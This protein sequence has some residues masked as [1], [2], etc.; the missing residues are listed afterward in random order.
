MTTIILLSCG[1]KKENQ[2]SISTPEVSQPAAEQ[3]QEDVET[4]PEKEITKLPDLTIIAGS[5][6][7]QG[8]VAPKTVCKFTFHVRNVGNGDYDHT[9]MV[10]GPGI[11]QGFSSLKAGETKTV[12]VEY[13]P[14][15]KNA[16]YTL[17]FKVDPDNVIKESNESNNESQTFTIKTT[18]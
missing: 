2:N 17:K 6:S 13:T 16:T 9:I 10:G 15:S 1:G 8:M 11:G 18:F 12:V 3:P 4:P 5:V 14:Y 7:P